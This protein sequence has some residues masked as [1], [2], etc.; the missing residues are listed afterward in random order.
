[1]KISAMLVAMAAL[2]APRL[3]GGIE[4]LANLGGLQGETAK[5]SMILSGAT[6]YGFTAEGGSGGNGVIFSVGTDGSGFQVLQNFASGPDPFGHQPHHGYLTLEGSTILRPI[7]RGGADG[8]GTVFSIQTDGSAPTVNHTFT[9]SPTTPPPLGDGAQPHSGLLHGGGNTYYGMTAFG[10]ASNSG[11]I[12][13]YHSA[14]QAVTT[15]YDFSMSTGGQP[16]GQLVWD[17]TGTFLLGMTRFG[18]SGVAN[19]KSDNLA[20]GV[21]FRFD[22]QSSTKEVL[23][24]FSTI[25]GG[26]YLSKHGILALGSGAKATTIFGLTA[27]GGAYDKGAIFQMDETGGTPLLLHSFGDG[28]DGAEPYGSLVMGLDGLFY[29]TTRKGGAHDD[30]TIFRI[31]QDGSSYEILGSFHALT[32]GSEP[33]DNVTFSPDGQTLYGLTQFGGPNGGGT[34]FA[35]AIPEPSTWALI[36]LASILFAVRLVRCR[37]EAK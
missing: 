26:P 13:S 24:D 23:A 18:G 2:A 35:L 15:L 9:G 16:H 32:T 30:G 6:L 33:I 11:V 19:A 5:G 8:Q 31:A 1:M 28:T 3:F 12:F 34:V 17:S 37:D 21:V 27:F 29:G 10:G 22:P 36:A 25:G 7:L 4:V 20:P 14:T